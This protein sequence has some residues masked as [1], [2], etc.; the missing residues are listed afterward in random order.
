MWSTN[1]SAAAVLKF[2]PAAGGKFYV[3]FQ[4]SA[5]HRSDRKRQ[6]QNLKHTIESKPVNNCL[7][8]LAYII[9]TQQSLNQNIFYLSQRV[10]GIV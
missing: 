8:N 1:T 7:R 2:Y 6:K 5:F 3:F 9:K 4:K 10:L